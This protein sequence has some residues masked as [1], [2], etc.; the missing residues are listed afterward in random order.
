M[1]KDGWKKLERGKFPDVWRPKKKG[2]SL[3]GTLARISK[4]KFGQVYR[5]QVGSKVWALPH[6]SVLINALEEAEVKAGVGIKVV[7]TSIGSEEAGDYYDYEVF[8]K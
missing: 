8:T 3:E 2:D 4:G 5:V 7:C 1:A 6:H